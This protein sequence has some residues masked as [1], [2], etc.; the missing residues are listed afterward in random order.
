MNKLSL[1]RKI[2]PA[3][4]IV[5][6]L[7]IT[8]ACSN[9][10]EVVCYEKFTPG[11]TNVTGPTTAN[12]NEEI[13]L[14]VSFRVESSCGQFIE[15]TSGDTSP[16]TKEIAVQ[17]EYDGCKCTIKP[18]T[19][20]ADYKFKA[21]TPGTYTLKFHKTSLTFITHTVVVE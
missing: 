12:V 19:R 4:I 20:I 16:T 14:T 7:T 18:F 11:V 10:N 3:A 6:L 1:F 17:A 5:L 13:S 21:A 8:T 9:E 2:L 15:F